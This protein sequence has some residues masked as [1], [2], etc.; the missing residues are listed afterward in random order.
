MYGYDRREGLKT[1]QVLKNFEEEFE[2][3]PKKRIVC[4]TCDGKG[5]HVNPSI[6]AHGIT[7]DEMHE[8]G[9]EFQEDYMSGV[10]D[11]SCYEC[12]GNNVV[13]AVDEEEAKH[14]DPELLQE[15]Y[16]WIQ[17]AYDTE[18]EYAAERRFGA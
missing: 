12:K 17:S 13:E 2:P 16:D 7:S 18:A 9:F 1:S 15:W 10:Y 5:K 6:D 11:V 3:L 8:L 14:R 4:P